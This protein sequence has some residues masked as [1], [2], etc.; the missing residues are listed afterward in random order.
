MGKKITRNEY[1]CRAQAIHG[2]NKYCYDRLIFNGIEEK[3]EVVCFKH[4]LFFPRASN[5]LYHASGCPE[6]KKEKLSKLRRFTAIQFIELAQSIHGTEKY[7]YHKVD[8]KGISKKVEIVC[9]KHG[10]FFP[11]A[12]DHIYKQTGCLS[13][14]NL[15]RINKDDFIKRSQEIHGLNTFGYSKINL[16]NIRT[17]VEL[18]CFIHGFFLTTPNN[19]LYQKSG[20]PKCS[21]NK[22]IDRDEF[23]KRAR[24]KHGNRY[25]YNKIIYKGNKIKI[26]IECRIHGYF[27]QKPNAH[28]SGNGCPKCANTSSVG[29]K[30]WLDSLGIPDSKQCRRVRIYINNKKFYIVDGYDPQTK[31]VYEFNGDF[32]H[33]NLNLYN[34]NTINYRT[35]TTFKQLYEKTLEKELNLINAGYRVVS[36]WQ[37]DWL[38][39]VNG[40][41]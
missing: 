27:W 34:A 30:L 21:D 15:A 16:I 37:S 10:S 8:Y 23:I 28:L 5:H 18:E 29:E 14:V 20:C 41:K 32:W 25:N 31:T 26:E 40:N 39:Q 4:G 24:L 13:C 19:H 7:G 6:C 1:I 9:V 3:V 12:A 11:I 38:K 35:K 2:T 17:P 33:G 36:I 22:K